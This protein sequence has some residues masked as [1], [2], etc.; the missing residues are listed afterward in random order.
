MDTQEH[1]KA[2]A[3]RDATEKMERN[4]EL[5][6]KI[7]QQKQNELTQSESPE[8]D[9]SSLLNNDGGDDSLSLKEQNNRRRDEGTDEDFG[10]EQIK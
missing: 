4:D 8:D 1:D 10:N 3:N 7:R 5:Q 9:D 2:K 6:N